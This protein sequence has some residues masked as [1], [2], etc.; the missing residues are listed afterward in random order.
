[1]VY[2]PITLL[3]AIG[4]LLALRVVRPSVFKTYFRKGNIAAPFKPVP[5]L[6]IHPKP[7]L[8]WRQEGRDLTI[9]ISVVTTII[10]YLQVIHDNGM[11]YASVWQILPF[12]IVL[13]FINSFVEEGITRLGVIVALKDAFSEKVI[14]IISSVVFG[15]AH[16]WGS[17][18]GIAGALAAG[19][20]GW[21]LA[22]SILETKG[23]F[24]AWL[25]HFLQDIIILTALFMSY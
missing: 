1:M 13:A 6:T 19:F 20:L 25:I 5:I 23:I 8:S 2:Q 17:P 11:N 21:I 15:I 7:S 14:Q 22:K 16:F 3:I 9:A 24:W 4:F 10:I 12:S 18:G